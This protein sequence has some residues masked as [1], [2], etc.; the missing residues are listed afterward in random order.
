MFD[1]LRPQ[2]VPCAYCKAGPVDGAVRTL[3]AA[4]GVLSVTW[5]TDA[6]PHLAAD[7][8]LAEDSS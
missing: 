3:C 1:P 2:T 5:H 8:I 7:R 4:E 6:C